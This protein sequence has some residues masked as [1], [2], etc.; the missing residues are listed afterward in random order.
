VI[1]CWRCW[2]KKNDRTEVGFPSSLF[3]V[4]WL[5][6][7]FV[8]DLVVVDREMMGEDERRYFFTDSCSGFFVQCV[9]RAKKERTIRTSRMASRR[10]AFERRRSPPRSSSAHSQQWHR[11]LPFFQ[12]FFS[13]FTLL[14]SRPYIFPA[15]PANQRRC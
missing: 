5:R 7:Y 10:L 15:T 3:T 12:T 8:C 14:P 9:A 1:V 6:G 13:I 11:V 2:G 4:S